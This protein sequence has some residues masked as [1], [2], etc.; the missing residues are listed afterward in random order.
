MVSSITP[1]GI[2]VG[3]VATIVL[4][5]FSIWGTVNERATAR[6]RGLGDQLDR[7]GIKMKPQELRRARERKFA[8][9]GSGY[10]TRGRVD[11]DRSID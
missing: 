2:F 11:S 3:V 6:V 5:F 4:T 9:M 10:L 1:I 7:A 8:V